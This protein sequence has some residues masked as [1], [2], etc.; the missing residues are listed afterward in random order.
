[1]ARDGS[2]NYSLPEAAFV[3]DTVISET[4]MNSNLSDMATALTGS[5]A[6]DGQTT[7]SGS[8]KMGSNKIT[9]LTAGTAA[10]EAANVGQMQAQAYIWCGT[11]GGTADALTLTPSPAITAYAAGQ[12]FRFIAGGDPNTGATTVAISGLT[13][14]AIQND[15]SALAA[16]DIVAGK[17]YQIVYDGT[18]FQLSRVHLGV[19]SVTG[20][21]GITGTVTGSGS[22]SLNIP[23]L[24]DETAVADADTIAIYDA[25]AS[26]HREMTRASFLA[27]GPLPR[28][29]L[30]GLGLSRAA[31]TDHDIT[32][33]VGEARDG[34]HTANLVL[35]AAIT[36]Q[37]DAAWAVGDA[38][39]GL[40][41]GSVGN[42]TWYHVWLIK[43]S[44]TGVVDALFSTSASSPTMPSDYDLKRRIGAVLT[45]GSANIIAFVQNGDTFLWTN[46]PVVSATN[47]GTSAV[48]RTLSTPL[49][50][51]TEA[52]VNVEISAVTSG[53]VAVY[54]SPLSVDDEA[55]T[56]TDAPLATL[57]SVNAA[58]AATSPSTQAR[59][60]T[61][62]SSA[63]R[64][65]LS[66]SG[67]SDALR[68]ATL[69]WVDRRG[70][71]D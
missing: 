61:D 25:S 12:H 27:G 67:S 68:I 43:R 8:L 4:A 19:V 7:M 51:V 36:K 32:V 35:A 55:V 3:Y 17:M 37:I 45:D 62:T 16:A 69:G 13:T 31:D 66:A 56:V 22:L 33:A 39:G 58:N 23:G 20:A 47:P 53:S 50:V 41:T 54:L 29:Y 2:G 46:P 21:G 10:T 64:S 38:Q 24:T 18:A 14:K 26:A 1:M 44:D 65:R 60:F 63:I 40:D 57:S 52:I 48:S 5:V 42:A 11:A 9:G 15:G 59:V 71:D 34:G 28:A 49:G 6:A 70:R 30:A